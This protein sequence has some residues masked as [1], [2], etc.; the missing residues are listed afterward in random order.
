MGDSP[1]EDLSHLLGSFA[2]PQPADGISGKT[3]LHDLPCAA[4]AQ[5][6]PGPSLYDSEKRLAGIARMSLS[7]ARCPAHGSFHGQ[8][9]L[10]WG[11]CIG[12]TFIQ[13]HDDVRSQSFLDGSGAFGGQVMAGTVEVRLKSHPLFGQGA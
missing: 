2:E 10:F 1:I 12:G 7:A 3:E 13:Y 11:T 6:L 9:L 8:L 5:I 4:L